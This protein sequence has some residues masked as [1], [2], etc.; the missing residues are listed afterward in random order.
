MTLGGWVVAAMLLGLTVAESARAAGDAPWSLIESTERRVV[1]AVQVPEPVWVAGEDG[2]GRIDVPGFEG[3]GAEGRRTVPALNLRVALP[4][5]AD[6][7]VR[8]EAID[9]LPI[10]HALTELMAVEGP[11]GEAERL[12][13]ADP[14]GFVR[15]GQPAWGTTQRMLELAV[16]PVCPD[17]RGGLRSP[18]AIRITVDFTAPEPAL[19]AAPGR[20]AD[21]AVRARAP[22]ADRDDVWA[23][24]LDRL[25]VNPASAAQWRRA[26]VAARG[27]AQAGD[28]L[29]NATTWVRLEV[30]RR[31]FYVITGDDLAALGFEPALVD[32]GRLRLF[33]APAGELR[34]DVLGELLPDWLQP[35]ALWVVDDGDGLWDEATRVYFL[36][37]GPD[38]WRDDLGLPALADDRYYTHPYASRFTYWLT[39]DGE[40]A[41]EPLWM[42]ERAA[43]PPEGL[44]LRASAHARAHLEENKIYDP[45]PRVADLPWERFLWV[46]LA[47]VPA[48][49][50]LALDHLVPGSTAVLRVSAWGRNTVFDNFVDHNVL[51][52]AQIGPL[53][54]SPPRIPLGTIAWDAYRRGLLDTEVTASSGE[55]RIWMSIP[56]RMGAENQPLADASYLGWIEC[57]YERDLI[58]PGNWLEFYVSAAEAAGGGWRI[59][60]L[61]TP[62]GWLLLDA[63]DPRSPVRLVPRYVPAGSSQAAEFSVTPAGE[64]ARLV[65]MK[66]AAAAAPARLTVPAWTRPLLR[67]R[68]EAVDYLIVAP[69]EFDTAAQMLAAHRAM[70]F[71]GANG[72]SPQAA[73]VALVDIQQIFDEFS[74]GQH[75]PTALRNFVRHAWLNWKGSAGGPTLS[76]LMLLGNAHYDPRG[77]LALGAT[78]H[79]PGYLYYEFALTTSP[80][81][82]P[83]HFGDDWFGMLDGPTDAWLDLALGRLPVMSASEATGVVEKLIRYDES[84]PQG[85][86]RSRLLLAAD[87]ICQSYKTDGLGWRHLRETEVLATSWVP[88]D[89][90]IVKLYMVE[91]G[92]QCIYDRKPEAA[93]DLLAHLNDG[94]LWFNFTG[95][96]SEVQL[97]DER[98]LETRSLGSLT[99]GEK[100]FFFLTAS[101]AVGKFAHGGD[102]LGVAA[103]RMAHGGAVAAFSASGLAE[104]GYNEALN[105]RIVNGVFPAG[106]LLK[107]VALGPAVWAAK[108]ANYNDRRYNLLGDPASRLAT[109]KLGI[110]LTLEQGGSAVSDTLAR[111]MMTVLT[112]QVRDCLGEPVTAFTG[113]VTME[114]RDSDLQRSPVPG[115][116]EYTLPGARIFATELPVSAG[117]L[118]A[119]FFVPTALLSGDRGRAR[120]YAYATQT[121]GEALD[122][123][124]LNHGLIIG[125]T[126][127]PVTDTAP[128]GIELRWEDPAATPQVGSRITAT[129]SD[130]SGLYVAALTPSR[131]VTVMILD[132]DDRYLAASDLSD[133]VQFGSNFRTGTLT[134]ALPAGLPTGQPL[135]LVLEASDNVMNRQRAELAFQMTTGAGGRLLGSVY[136]MPNPVERE[137]H[138][139]VE[140]ARSADVEITIYAAT[141]RVVRRLSE[142]GVSRERGRRVGVAWDGRDDD[143]DGLANGVYFYRVVAREPGGG[144]DERI[145]RL[146][147]FREAP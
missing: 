48:K 136:N 124:G 7:T 18:R 98:L 119:E 2:T 16:H 82:R 43:T 120:I 126:G 87:D 12:S 20:A 67:E 144:R 116:I 95:H 96:G 102:G 15:Y 123:G 46:D 111:G 106:T 19:L 74:G 4:P 121:E 23:P 86:W 145:E 28:G 117:T 11:T 132:E 13:Y 112:G 68:T 100:L 64:T 30:E 130:S 142:T 85:P 60:G 17:A 69:R 34:E 104:A 54:S 138:F 44:T 115:A 58:M 61:T 113:R 66:L 97:A 94:V 25:V 141:G 21:P 83:E 146:V 114:V 127:G 143:G 50:D 27:A 73:R 51:V 62:D 32:L 92:S 105:K 37:N 1:L 78:D 6:F 22:L 36:G 26:P 139:L 39:W 109:P 24:L 47:G 49:I 80:E 56:T 135:R 91:Y 118:A 42:E 125:E 38:G 108:T 131:A 41:T 103:V 29:G 110:D 5:D 31:G 134:Y 14:D 99:N 45:R 81:W 128:P 122:A 52:E 107:P 72:D 40:F 129:L 79:L 33:C 140:L 57:E 84:P 55:M 89:A 3:W 101:C 75:D 88:Q 76:H 137:T 93:G 77:Y 133:Q 65:M 147:V 59:T 63:S 9:L 35:C 90:D 71:Y 10:G 70:R 8:A 53:A